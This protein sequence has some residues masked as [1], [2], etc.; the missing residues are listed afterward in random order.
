VS[1]EI[2]AIQKGRPRERRFSKRPDL[3]HDR[4]ET[5]KGWTGPKVV[6]GLQV[7]GTFRAHQVPLD[8]YAK[9]PE[10][11][12]MLEDWMKSYK[13]EELFDAERQADAGTGGTGSQGHR[14]MGANPNANG[15]IADEGSPDAGFRNY[16]VDV[17]KPGAPWPKL[18]AF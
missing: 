6:D 14:R 18:R 9:K 1:T 13:P 17:P 15:G 12:K 4:F 10:H 2:R 11:V 8:D 5:P 16:A 7:E 3:A